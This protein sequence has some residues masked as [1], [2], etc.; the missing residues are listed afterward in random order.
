MRN[1]TEHG[2]EVRR[3]DFDRRLAQM[4]SMRSRSGAGKARSGPSGRRSGDEI[5]EILTGVCVCEA[6]PENRA[7]GVVGAVGAE[8]EG[9]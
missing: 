5:N 1:D 4:E 2:M 6:G 3:W 7:A 8:T 9:S